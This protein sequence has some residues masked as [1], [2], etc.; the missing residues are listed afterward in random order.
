M[1]E[2]SS[3]IGPH[4][5]REL[6][7]ML[8]GEKKL[9]MFHDV[10]REEYESPEEIIPEKSFAAYCRSGEIVRLA[11]D[12]TDKKTG[13]VIRYV[14]FAL[15]GQEWRAQTLLWLNRD[16]YAGFYSWTACEDIMTGR[17]L[18]YREAQINAF[19]AHKKEKI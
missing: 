15:A 7:L 9:A 8:S 18:G 16:Y 12:M 3:L 4:E 11:E 5:G 6:A 10:V 17:L 1:T 13:S 14:C 2:G 19:L